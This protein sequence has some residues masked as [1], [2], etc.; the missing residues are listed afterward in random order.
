MF[1]NRKNDFKMS[2]LAKGGRYTTVRKP[3]LNKKVSLRMSSQ[4]DVFVNEFPYERERE[5]SF[6]NKGIP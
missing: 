6:V 3:S 2:Q 4:S 5:F 1:D